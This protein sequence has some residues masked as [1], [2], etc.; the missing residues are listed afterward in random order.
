PHHEV[1]KPHGLSQIIVP[2]AAK[3]AKGEA[4][5]ASEGVLPEDGST[6]GGSI[7]QG[8]DVD[9]TP[10]LEWRAWL[11]RSAVSPCRSCCCRWS[12]SR[13]TRPAPSA[14]G[15]PSTAPVPATRSSIASST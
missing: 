1:G 6:E 13:R 9:L 2:H 14:A 11:T 10:P 12:R 3:A 8:V 7:E 5:E 4:S 15:S